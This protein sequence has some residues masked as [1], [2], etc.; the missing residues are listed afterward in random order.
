MWSW[1]P[2]V[3]LRPPAGH[4]RY[5]RI[6]PGSGQPVRPPGQLRRRGSRMSSIRF[7]SAG[8]PPRFHPTCV[9]KGRDPRRSTMRSRS[10]RLWGAASGG[11]A[12]TVV[13]M[14]VVLTPDVHRLLG[15]SEPGW[16]TDVGTSVFWLLVGS[17]G[18]VTAGGAL[19]AAFV[20]PGPA[21]GIVSPAA[22]AALR[23]VR[24]AAATWAVA[25]A[26]V[27]FFS[28]AQASGRPVADAFDPALV[29]GRGGPAGGPGAGR[30]ARGGAAGAGGT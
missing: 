12:V 23:P 21:S 15:D 26:A 13:V 22:Y 3:L 9:R 24:Y 28:A 18:A 2:M 8:T 6:C 29:P 14:I 1:F 11:S 7:P 4:R 27:V 30:G 19:F 17:A 25:A 16:W 10:A 5:G 20:V